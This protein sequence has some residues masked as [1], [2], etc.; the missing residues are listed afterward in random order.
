ML[1]LL[2]DRDRFLCC[3]H[4]TASYSPILGKGEAEAIECVGNAQVAAV[5]RGNLSI[6]AFRLVAMVS[7]TVGEKLLGYT[8]S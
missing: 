8:Q 4:P 3:S 7:A 1:P 6:A 5:S 2:R